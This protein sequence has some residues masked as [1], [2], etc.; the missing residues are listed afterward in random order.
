MTSDA[1]RIPQLEKSK[2]D[3]DRRDARWKTALQDPGL[4]IGGSIIAVFFVLAVCGWLG[5]TP[6]PVVEQ[7]PLSRLTPP[8]QEFRFGTDQF[9]RDV[10]SRVMKGTANSLQVALLSVA[11]SASVGTLIG[12]VSGYVGGWLDTLLMRLMDVLFAFPG[13]LLALLVVTILGTGLENTIFAIAVVYTP[14]F[15]RVARGPV[16]SVK[17]QEYVL[18]ARCLGEHGP[19]ILWRHVLPNIAG[20]MTVQVTLA[21][22]W[23][24][25]TEAGLSF[26]GLGT[27]QPEPSL[28]LM[29]SSNRALAEIA[30]WLI[31]FPGLA[32]MLMV[33]GFNLLGDGL[34][35][36]FD[37][38][39]RR[40]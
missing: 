37:P 14:I 30:P 10:L 34:R 16:L 7:N 22:S 32:I 27:Q 12:A 1:K 8:S 21:L 25:I 28:G 29:L 35:D 9:G 36:A 33:L 31:V 38:R 26:L 19:A 13:L 15:A 24:L 3:D 40:A 11:L 23:A 6:Y 17:E 4:L 5:W 20:V 2:R 18:A 39:N